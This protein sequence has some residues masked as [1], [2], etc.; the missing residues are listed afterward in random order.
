MNQV[1]FKN[2]LLA[3]QLS[4]W[5]KVNRSRLAAAIRYGSGTFLDIGCAKGE[6]VVAL[7]NKGFMAYGLDLLEGTHWGEHTIPCIVGNALKLPFGNNS[8]DTILAFEVIEHIPHP[9]RALQEF[10][11]VCKKTLILSV[12][13]CESVSDLERAGM[14]HSHWMDRTHCNF[15]SPN[16]L[17]CMLED[18]GFH[19]LT[20]YLINRIFIDYPLFRSFHLPHKA[21]YLLSRGLARL[22]G[23][24]QYFITILAVATKGNQ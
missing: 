16:T 19:L 17:T 6:Y 22:P 23:R 13:N 2:R 1:E 12:P 9:E 7:N 18:N 21:A 4:S 11:R 5:G 3:A 8:F 20:I 14:A 15:F 10:F 24:K